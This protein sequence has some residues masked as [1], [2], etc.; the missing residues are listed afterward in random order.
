MTFYL[1]KYNNYYNRILKRF[2][3]LSD[4]LKEPYYSGD[5]IENVNFDPNDCVNTFQIVN[6]NYDAD[7]ALLVDYGE[8]VSICFEEFGGE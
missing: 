5:F 4:Y 6:S 2:L 7:Y 3:N 8:I 1:L